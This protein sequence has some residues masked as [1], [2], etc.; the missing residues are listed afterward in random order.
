MAYGL[1][2]AGDIL[3]RVVD[4][5]QFSVQEECVFYNECDTYTPFIKQNKPVFNIEYPDDR[6][7]LSL[8]KFIQKSCSDKNAKGFSQLIKKRKLDAWT[9]TCPAN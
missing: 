4:V 7:K 6:P 8:D 9:R 5:S 3:D 1:K 2:N